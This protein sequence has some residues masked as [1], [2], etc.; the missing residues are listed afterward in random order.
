MKST[1]VNFPNQQ[2]E[3]LAGILDQPPSPIAFAIYAHCF[4]CSKDIPAAFHISKLLANS[5]ISVLR[6]DFTGLGN[7]QG[8]FSDTNFTT[9]VCDII[10]AADYLRDN[11]KAPKL[12]IGHSLGGT[13]SIAAATKIKEV[14]AVA[15]IAS[16]NKPSHVLTHF[17]YVKQKLSQQ[18]EI[19]IDLIGREFTIKKQ[20]LDDIESYNQKPI[21]ENLKKPILIMHS[22]TDTVVS[23]QEAS[24]LFTAAKH[25]KSYLSLDVIDHLASNKEDA[26]YIANNIVHWANRYIRN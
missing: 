17:E 14:N 15:T 24:N 8:D 5:N 21:I 3:L 16:P 13:A 18:A 23:V 11:F 19:S 7:S 9:N 2:G 12:L 20:L 10:C 6:F 26:E 22:P 25:P 1:P 4:T